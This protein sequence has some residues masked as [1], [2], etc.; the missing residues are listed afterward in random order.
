MSLGRCRIQIDKPCRLLWAAFLLVTLVSA[1]NA[2]A[3]SL[4]S[5][6]GLSAATHDCECATKC[7]GDSCCCGHRE[8]HTRLPAPEPT[9]Q[10]D[11]A[12]YSPCLL[13]SAPCGGSGL[14]NAP[15]SDYPVGRIAALVN[16]GHLVLPTVSSLIQLS[17]LNFLPDRRASRLN[18]PPKRLILA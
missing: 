4:T 12:N 10:N 9:P 6:R 14:P 3:A 2:R 1:Q 7:L 8:H 5:A 11:R 15:S 13:N 16:A 18:R 17:T